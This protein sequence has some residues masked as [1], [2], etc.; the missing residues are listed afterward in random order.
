MP[1][2]DEL[3]T[4][5]E[6]L[7]GF[8][9]KRA[10]LLLFQIE[11]RAA[12]LAVQSR[13]MADVYLTV[14]TAEQSELAFLEALAEGREPPMR[15]TIYDLERYAPQWQSLVPR[16]PTLQAAIAHLLGEKYRFMRSDIPHIR[17]VLHLDSAS[18]QRA[19]LQHYQQPL[20]AIY[21]SK[22]GLLEQTGWR[23]NRLSGWLEQIPPFW[24]AYALTFTQVVGASILALPIALAEIGPLAGIVVLVVIGLLNILTIASMAEAVTRNGAIRYQGSYLGRLVQDYLGKTGSLLL[25]VM[26]VLHCTLA[27]LALYFGFS[28][29]L[30][31][32]TPVPAVIWAALLFLLACAY[33]RSNTLHAT[34]T[35]ALVVG[36]MTLILILLLSA[37][38][39]PHLQLSRLLYMHVPLLDGRPFEPAI[40]GLIFGVVLC[41]YFGHF[42]V[43][44]CANVVLQRDPSGR[45]L[46]WGCVAAQV[47]AMLL[48]ILWTVV[49]NGSI[50]A[51]TLAGLSS[52]VLTPLA[53]QIG[54]IATLCGV[55]LTLLAM[56]MASI[57]LS[58]TL[59]LLVRE[60][61]PLTSRHT[62]VLG[63]RR[64]RLIFLLR[65]KS[66]TRMAFTYLGLQ[67]TQ[68]YFRLD[69][70]QG[71][72]MRRFEISVS[73]NWEASTFLMTVA[74]DLATQGLR[75]S[76][77]VE[78]A[79]S[80]AVRVQYTTSLRMLYEGSQ[81]VLGFDILAMAEQAEMET[82]TADLAFV[83]WLAGREEA[84]AEEVMHYFQGAHNSQAI[85]ARLIEQGMVMEGEEDDQVIYKLHFMAR[86]QRH[87]PAQL[88]Q[89]LDE[90]EQEADE[91]RALAR[92]TRWK[93][94]WK[95]MQIRLQGEKARSWLGLT[96]LLLIFLL[97]EWL[98]ASGL[99]SF[100][101][102]MSLRGIITVPVVAGVFP[103]LLLLA[104]R[105]KG[106]RVPS[107]VFSLLAHPVV[108]GSIYLIAVG[109]LFLHG[110][111]IWQNP[112]QKGLAVLVGLVVVAVTSI[113]VGQGAFAHRLVIEL[114]Q[115]SADANV[116][117]AAF[118]VMNGGQPAVDAKIQ[119]V[120]S[121]GESVYQ[122]ASGSIPQFPELSSAK[123]SLSALRS[124]ELKVWAHRVSADGRTEPLAALVKVSLASRNYEFH[125]EGVRQEFVLPLSR[126]SK[127]MASWEA[128]HANQLEVEVQLT[129]ATLW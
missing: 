48:Y 56:G 87:I 64:G 107:L 83:H 84:S 94:W 120:Y 27:L 79:T 112:Y 92:Q 78:K 118:S 114:R 81:D 126:G 88:K 35:S 69:I 5:D 65:D 8:S 52:T 44:S 110:L 42:A 124:R 49:V 117:N 33:V 80:E 106:E 17:E 75:L 74:P 93:L 129:P 91:E 12:S 97:A 115:E 50:A 95:Q 32:A 16:T 24:T 63:R 98:I 125:I 22:T 90:S 61:L 77:H 13:Q 37:L 89:L 41:A 76:L 38:A 1:I 25:T 71:E 103:V 121:D 26:V 101:E 53:H 85:V 18:V 30:A 96:P 15:P 57:H 34:V 70:Q 47:S 128:E 100:P 113:M 104:S 14:D 43:S 111:L 127:K 105:R 68:P 62:L 59:F 21:L 11:S 3:F 67:E 54:P 60:R 40:L 86:R 51:Q 72:D 23:W 20:D 102:L 109:T 29:T 2:D 116:S 4:P 122:V 73:T 55:L 58:L 123:F 39:L 19:Y 6:V 108:A 66:Q 31:E 9:A 36:A 99:E 82:E 45:S 7:G 46:L 28:L 10:R 119:L